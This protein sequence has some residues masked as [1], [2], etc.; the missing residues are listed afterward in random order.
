F[1]FYN[2]GDP[3]MNGGNQLRVSLALG[4]GGL[5]QFCSGGTNNGN[6]CTSAANC[7]GGTCPP[8]NQTV[9]RVRFDLDCVANSGGPPCTDQGNVVQYMGDATITTTC[10]GVTWTSTTAQAGNEIVFTPST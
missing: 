2:P 4:T 6:M 5:T 3:K 9:H 10:A 8:T 7:P 1:N